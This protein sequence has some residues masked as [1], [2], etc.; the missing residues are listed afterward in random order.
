MHP[1]TGDYTEQRKNGK[2]NFIYYTFTPRPLKGNTFFKIDDEL[3]ALLIEAHHNLGLLEGLL[4][5]APNKNS[6]CE[7]ML[8]KEC[9]YSRMID[10]YDA[11]DF[12]N[13]LVKR[14]VGKGAVESI[15]NLMSAYKSA[16]DM[17]FAAQEYSKIC[18]IALYGDKAE[19]QIGIRNTQTFLQSAISNLKTYNPTAPEDVL[20]SLPKPFKLEGMQRIDETPVH[21]AV[22][23]AFVNLIIHADY[24]MDAGTLKVIKRNKSFEF[25][26]P[27]I[28]KL[29]I[30]DIFRGGNSKPR[31]PHMQTMLRMVGFGDNAGSGFPTILATW[32]KEGWIEPE[33]IEDTRLN[34]VTLVLK[35]VKEEKTQE[36]DNFNQKN[37]RSLSEVL[38]EVLTKKDFDKV[39]PIIEILEEKG[40]VTPKEAVEVCNKSTATVRR[41]M[42]ILTATGMV[43]AAGNTNNSIYRVAGTM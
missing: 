30:E 32:K 23:E 17:Q 13:I 2:L 4:Q 33:L 31:N 10:Y 26:N 41:Y 25:T 16:V 7:L 12:R 22:R 28:L 19:Q 21:K 15:N 8:L 6:F 11:L 29:P 5:Y 38:S 43:V 34:Q 9:T 3:M 1:Y 42:S 14:E 36:Q 40:C 35:M 27:G 24:L 39:L 18:S 20:P 37:E